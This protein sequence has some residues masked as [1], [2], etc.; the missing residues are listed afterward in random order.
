MPYF[1][2]FE[3]RIF[4]RAAAIHCCSNKELR[5]LPRRM[6]RA[7]PFIVPQ[8]I[9]SGL[10]ELQPDF[11]ELRR[12]C[13]NLRDDQKVILY[14]GRISAIKRLEV[15]VEAFVRL[16]AEFPDWH[17]MVAGPHEDTALVRGLERRIEAAGLANRFTMP[18]MVLDELKAACLS[19]ADVFAQPSAHENFGLSLAEALLFEL[20]CVT[21]NGVA[22]SEDV[23]ETGAGI[24]CAPATDAFERGL[25]EMLS[26]EDRRSACSRAA[27]EVARRFSP[28]RVA[29][30][31]EA[32][33]RSCMQ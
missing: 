22:L 2:L 6:L 16:S 15:L 28:A 11:D 31:L 23:A 1:L 7:R 5:E 30:R 32:E 24:V 3:R 27:R 21:S 25:R 10:L 12:R 26:S 18:G 19:R 17:L 14:L 33:Y 20:P 29:E 13:P 4:S 9:R 8:P